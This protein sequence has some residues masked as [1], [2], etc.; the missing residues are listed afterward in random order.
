MTLAALI[1]S[2]YSLWPWHT[3]VSRDEHLSKPLLSK[4]I[5]GWCKSCLI[6]GARNLQASL[7]KA[8][9]C[10]AGH[11]MRA[12]VLEPMVERV[13]LSYFS[14]SRQGANMPTVTPI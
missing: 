9:H 3:D 1:M 8:A 12:E 14:A 7:L 10:G 13:K 2:R 11:R 5:G 4:T 6:L